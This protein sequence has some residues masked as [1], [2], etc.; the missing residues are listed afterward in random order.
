VSP[1]TLVDAPCEQRGVSKDTPGD[2][3]LFGEFEFIFSTKEFIHKHI[4]RKNPTKIN[5]YF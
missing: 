1:G 4:I 5:I 3:D 2:R